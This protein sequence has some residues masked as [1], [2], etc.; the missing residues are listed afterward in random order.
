[1]TRYQSDKSTYVEETL[2]AIRGLLADN[3]VAG[4]VYGRLKQPYSTWRKLQ[5]K[6]LELAQLYGPDRLPRHRFRPRI[7]LPRLG[8]GP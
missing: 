2:G 7:L 3:E 5:Q 1:M 8:L 6:E 4:T